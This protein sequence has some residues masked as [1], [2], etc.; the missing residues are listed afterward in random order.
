MRGLFLRGLEAEEAVELLEAVDRDETVRGM[1]GRTGVRVGEASL[2]ATEG[3][4]V[5]EDI[6]DIF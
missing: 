1:F 3:M 5:R 4:E 6:G 2:D